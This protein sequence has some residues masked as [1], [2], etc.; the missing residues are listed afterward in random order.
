MPGPASYDQSDSTN[1]KTYTFGAKSK[2]VYNQNPGPGA[3]D[4][5]NQQ[6]KEST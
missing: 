2:I 4:N 5:D 1:I 6:I 3:Y